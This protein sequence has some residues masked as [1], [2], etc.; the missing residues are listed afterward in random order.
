MVSCN[1]ENYGCS[2]GFLTPSLS[3]LIS[4]GVV[5]ESCMEYEGVDKMCP[6]HCDDRYQKFKKYS[7]KRGT[8]KTYVTNEEIMEDLYT[9]GPMMV[10]FTIYEDFMSYGSGV[11][12]PTTTTV[13]GRHAVKLIGWDYDGNGDLYWICQNQWGTSW[14]DSGYFEIKAGVAGIDAAGWSCDPDLDR[15]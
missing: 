6:F 13:S 14:G 11:Y 5:S 7:C 15:V 9:N 10:G 12:S 8:L 4:E 1:F 3:Y 2:G